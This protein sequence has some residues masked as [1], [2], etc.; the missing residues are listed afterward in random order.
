MDRES[1]LNES[2]VKP[3]KLEVNE[4]SKKNQKA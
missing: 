2:F 4:K 1:A 3:S